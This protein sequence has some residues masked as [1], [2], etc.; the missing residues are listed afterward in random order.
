MLKLAFAFLAGALF[1]LGC[2]IAADAHA[3]ALVLLGAGSQWLLWILA[4]WR[5][6]RAAAAVVV[7]RPAR[8]RGASSPA[9]PLAGTAAEVASALKGLG[10]DRAKAERATRAALASGVEDF[11]GLF[12]LALANVKGRA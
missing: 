6:D 8:S 7:K 9:A 1:V 3:A 10:A 11:D 4:R 2:V 12:R 5:Q